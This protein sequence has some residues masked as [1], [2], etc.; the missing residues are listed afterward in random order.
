MQKRTPL[1][2]WS[3]R[4]CRALHWLRGSTTHSRSLNR[5]PCD[6]P[7][8][9][10]TR[11]LAL[12]AVLLL[13]APAWAADPPT[14]LVDASWPKP[15]PHGWVLGEVSGIATD[16][17]DHVWIIQRSSLGPAAAPPVIEF[18]PEGR[19]V[20]GW[21]GPG[22]GYDWVANGHGIHV[23]SDGF[24]WIAGNG[25][26]DGQV[27]KF[28]R[29]GKFVLQIGHPG[30]AVDSG[31]VTKL[32]R[33]TDMQVDPVARELYVAD[34]Y[35]NHRVIVFDADTGA[36]K[37][38][39]GAYGSRPTDRRITYDPKAAPARQFG[40]PVHCV[41]LSHDGLVYVCDRKNDRIQVFRHD[42]GFVAEWFIK[43]ATRGLGSV[44]DLAF[45]PDPA[46]SF[47]YNADGINDEVRI[48]RRADGVVVGTFGH[49]GR[50]PGEF[51]W[52]HSI[53]VDS[54]GDVFTTEVDKANR[55][56]KF[57]P[58]LSTR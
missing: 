41:K 8:V 56:Q 45:S 26:A 32:S 43:P 55:V 30:I 47:L 24:I 52:V 14:L 19:V 58:V 1:E 53:A 31:D 35:G 37:R 27:L 48:L 6:H 15:L 25:T 44:W 11:L 50:R 40:N 42:G 13:A 4:V 39:W 17:R 29:N 10:L 12:L 23:D 51:H 2:A 5:A 20:Q 33:P 49:P 7:G 54:H 57:A 9:P 3:C 18:D 38:Q 16:E 21:G 46:Q 34:G 28:S 22:Q 36:Y